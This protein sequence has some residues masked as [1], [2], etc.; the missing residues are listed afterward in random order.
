M[1]TIILAGGTGSRLSPL[2]NGVNKHL[3]PMGDKCAF[4][5]VYEMAAR[6]GNQIIVVTNPHDIP[7]FSK[8]SPDAAYIGQGA[9]RGTADALRYAKYV[10]GDEDCFVM[11][12]DNVFLD[13]SDDQLLDDVRLLDNGNECGVWGFGVD[14]VREFGMAVC[15]GND[16]KECKLQKII[17]KPVGAERIPGNAVV[18]AYYFPKAVWSYLD[19]MQTTMLHNEYCLT[20]IVNKFA[21]SG[22]AVYRDLESGNWFDYG[23]SVRQYYKCLSI[24]L[25]TSG[26][27]E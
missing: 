23:T 17:E 24:I 13:G 15:E 6:L 16:T 7:N 10:A 25:K 3:L 9:A 8:V 22:T 1:K 20:S 19:L 11:L 2:S 12:A 14:D 26:E 4:E 18:G 5:I 21:E 27:R